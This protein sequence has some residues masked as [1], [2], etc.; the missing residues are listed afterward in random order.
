[1]LYPPFIRHRFA[2]LVLLVVSLPGQA[3]DFLASFHGNADSLQATARRLITQPVPAFNLAVAHRPDPAALADLGLEQVYAAEARSF[4]MRDR[5]RL[6]AYRY[7]G[8][9]TTTIVLL[10][11]VASSAYLLNKTAGLLRQATRATVYAVDL[12]G[13]G[14][15]E[16]KPGD[17]DSLDQYAT[18]VADLV[19]TLRRETPRAKIILAGHSMGG[20]IALQYAQ[21]HP[22]GVE[23]LLLFAPLLGQDFF[24]DLPPTPPA[25]TADE[26]FL[27]VHVPRIIGLKMLN[28]LNRHEADSLPVLFLN[29][30]ATAPLRH[31]TYRANQSMAPAHVAPALRALRVPLLVVVGSRDEAFPAAAVRRAVLASGRGKVVVVEGATHN[32]IR[33]DPRTYQL[34]RQWHATL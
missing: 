12:R 28:S 2:L 34:I 3:Q 8:A 9:P 30:P 19:A 23:G 10:H 6:A 25:A 29:V 27:K 11:G 33:H 13:H 32:G 1:M 5:R 21:A 26:P 24:A 18:D 20:G 22:R 15:S 7:A 4:A 17:V 16:G 14:G 31:Y